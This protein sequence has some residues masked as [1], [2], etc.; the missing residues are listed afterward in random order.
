MADVRAVIFDVA[1]VLVHWDPA[2]TL[3]GVLDADR[4]ADFLAS[5]ELWA[6]N[7][8]S[9]AGLP[10][11]ETRARVEAEVPGQAEAF[12]LYLDRFTLSVP[13]PVEGTSAV[14]EEL[15]DAGVPAYGLSNWS[16]ENFAIARAA[17]PVIERLADVIVSGEVGLAKPD[18]A[19]F[20]LALDRFG[21]DPATTVMIDD[22]V[23]NLDAAA[24]VGLAT[25]H[26]T[27]AGQL[28]ADLDALGVPLSRVEPDR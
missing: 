2:L 7:A 28:R 10:L 5:E 26:F 12:G 9:D 4:V 22:T 11:A 16:A 15:L 18:E 21:L 27:S 19:I 13:G 1:N 14:V 6:I 8:H 20:T 3:H 25:L 24:R 17:A 23:V